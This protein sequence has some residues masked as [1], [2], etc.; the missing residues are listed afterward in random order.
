MC[1]FSV[2]SEINGISPTIVVKILFKAIISY[3]WRSK[4]EDIPLKLYLVD[5]KEVYINKI[6]RLFENEAENQAYKKKKV[7]V[8][9]L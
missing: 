3:K 4:S 8:E 5:D 6:V 1:I 9:K 2:I 7:K